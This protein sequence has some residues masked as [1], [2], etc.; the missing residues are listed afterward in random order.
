[1]SEMAVPIL[2]WKVRFSVS[3]AKRAVWCFL[4]NPSVMSLT[5]R[6]TTF[7]VLSDS[8]NPDWWSCSIDAFSRCVPILAKMIFSATL[9]SIDSERGRY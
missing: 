1:M 4:L 7:V 2:T 3:I 6:S 9:E 8:R 5:S